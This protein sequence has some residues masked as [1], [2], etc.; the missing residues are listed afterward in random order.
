MQCFPIEETENSKEKNSGDFWTFVPITSKNSDSVITKESL[1]V[2]N[3]SCNFELK[4]FSTEDKQVEY[5]EVK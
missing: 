2:K 1:F 3:Y 4:S 5:A